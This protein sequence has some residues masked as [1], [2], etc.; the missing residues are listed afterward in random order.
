MEI[1]FKGTHHV[2]VLG[3]VCLTALHWNG[4]LAQAAVCSVFTVCLGLLGWLATAVL[5]LVNDTPG[6]LAGH[7]PLSVPDPG[8]I[9]SLH[10][11]SAP[12]T[13]ALVIRHFPKKRFELGTFPG[14]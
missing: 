13:T 7:T 4:L 10:T 14:T 8:L 3:I 2:S 12:V 11:C 1:V 9:H 6:N 5:F